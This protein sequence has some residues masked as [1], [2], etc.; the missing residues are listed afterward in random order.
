[1][2]LFW[3]LKE[4]LGLEERRPVLS[5]EELK[6]AF[7]RQ[8]RNF[9]SLLTANNNALELMAEIDQALA[10]GRPFSMAF[11]RGHCTAL[12]AN[13]LKMIHLLE[14]LGGEHYGRLRPPFQGITGELEEIMT[15][16][17]EL[18]GRD[19]ILPLAQLDRHR[20][21]EAG[22][23]MANLGEIRNRI[24]LPTPEGFVITAAATRHFFAASNLQVEINRRLTS[25]NSDRLADVYAA[26]AAI[27]RLIVAAPLP[28]D[29]EEQILEHHARLAGEEKQEILVAMRSSALGED[30]SRSSFA[31]MY[32]TRLQVDAASLLTAYK[33]IVAGKYRPQ[34]MIYRLQRGFRHQDVIMCVGCLAMV[35]GVVSG[36]MYSRPPADLRGD[37]VEI[38]AAP[39]LAD[40]VV[41][42]RAASRH[43]RVARG[44]S[45]EAAPTDADN[46]PTIK[47]LPTADNGSL[48]TDGKFNSPDIGEAPVGE[49]LTSA[50]LSEMA[51][52]ALR[53]E[54][55]FGAPQDIEWSLGHDG[56]VYLLQSRP[57]GGAGL[58]GTGGETAPANS[59]GAKAG[60]ESRPPDQAVNEAAETNDWRAGST[61]P[62]TSDLLLRGG[63][64]VVSGVAAGSV[65]AV[66]RD[67][68]LLQ[69]PRQAVLLV[70]HPL[71]EWA[72]VLPRAAAIIS[73]TG[74]SAAHLA[75]VAREFGVPAI[76]G[77]AGAMAELAPGQEV[78]VD[79]TGLRVHAGRRE[80]LLSR[81]VPPP[82]LMVGSPV[83]Q[84]LSQ[85]AALVT[86][87]N[88][89]DPA[90]PFFRPENCRTLHDITRYCHE[91]AVA[92]M[93]AFG[94]RQ[95]FATGAAKQLVDQSPFTW[96]VIDL[97]DGFAPAHDPQESFIRLE[98]IVS[99]PMLALWR[100]M[101]AFPW[102]GPPPVNLR[103]FG[104]ILFR[105]TMNPDL[106]PA[107]RSNLS[108]RSYF[109]ISR[110]FCNMSIR[111]G[112]H[113]ALVESHISD[114]LTENY[115]SFQF[116][117]GA[118][119]DRR[120]LLRLE[121]IG[122]VLGRY[123][124]R[125]SRKE[126]ALTA[127]LEKMEA[128]FL[129]ERLKV[130][131]YL[132]IHTRQIDMVMEDP[133]MVAHYRQKIN[134]DL[135]SLLTPTKVK[136]V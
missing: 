41:S 35:D 81:A 60:D 36:V 128:P 23:K 119:D 62:P 14:S 112:Y 37:W 21:D 134:R 19:F 103:G 3:R 71:P 46:E 29:L 97:E 17:P 111:L 39:G 124:F 8:Y 77:L 80:D 122:E 69:F 7:R 65:F 27:E 61:T 51:A 31:G 132:L 131:G 75:T 33:E 93:F 56:R 127:R 48:E 110:N 78:T 11:V 101:T 70:A 1:M 12:G 22:E 47:V 108:A 118:A 129:L 5:G 38:T 130:L 113:F 67:E 34:A 68:D 116:K 92:E 53:L 44:A 126:D 114:L 98:H 86:P 30:S 121:L 54:A 117:G 125:V 49:L 100:G 28:A 55:H 25:L 10:G 72:V 107:V 40:Q 73:E 87:L 76:F 88:L 99:A 2:S 9:R 95:G 94:D 26:S 102:Q 82:K 66:R 42:G 133:A 15:R 52:I 43:F 79:A 63:S 120:R 50:Q 109:L 24:G 13:V 106:E 83:H 4:W 96:W 6:V 84:V 74:E 135:E 57:L 64:C 89:I 16:E 136:N 104:A 32:R 59:R 20:A 105:S 123:D 58:S 45:L 90:S 91:K 85:V 115:V 18:A